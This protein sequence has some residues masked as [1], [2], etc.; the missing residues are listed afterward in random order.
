M[1]WLIICAALFLF[2]CIGESQNTGCQNPNPVCGS[3]G[4]IYKTSC[5]A[6]AAGVTVVDDSFCQDSCANNSACAMNESVDT[7]S[8]GVM[9]KDSTVCGADGKNYEN[10]T[11]LGIFNA[12]F[13]H[14]GTC[15]SP[16]KATDCPSIKEL[17]CG[18][19]KNT[20]ENYCFAKMNNASVVH[21]GNCS[22]GNPIQR[23]PA[24]ENIGKYV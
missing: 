6:T 11:V 8:E 10:M 15:I 22:D 3:D 13:I 16:K 24:C 12:T 5:D 4:R 14:N 19:D 20:Y 1:Y 18:S 17:V 21:V 2:G 23:C 9:E 7:D